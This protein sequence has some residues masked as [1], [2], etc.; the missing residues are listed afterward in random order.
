M[1]FS[2]DHSA[3]NI[4]RRIE[5]TRK[6]VIINREGARAGVWGHQDLRSTGA[7]DG[8][9]VGGGGEQGGRC[10]LTAMG[11]HRQEQTLGKESS[12]EMSVSPGDLKSKKGRL[13]RRQCSGVR[14]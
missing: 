11:R 5:D 8:M 3:D 12:L 10:R 14:P 4:K 6:E 13:T 9:D 1:T 7:G 2:K